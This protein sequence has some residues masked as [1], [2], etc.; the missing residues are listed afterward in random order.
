MGSLASLLIAA[1]FV[2]TNAYAGLANTRMDFINDRAL[3]LRVV[4]VLGL[5]TLAGTFLSAAHA[6]AASSQRG[7]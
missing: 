4:L 3:A 6:L 5:A 1:R 7:W 2:M